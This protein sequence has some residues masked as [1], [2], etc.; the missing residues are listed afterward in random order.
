MFIAGVSQIPIL[1][2]F[3]SL[4]PAAP[5]SSTR[6]GFQV[7]ASIVAQGQAVV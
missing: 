4:A 3:T 6:S 5:I 2:S 7:Q 1:F